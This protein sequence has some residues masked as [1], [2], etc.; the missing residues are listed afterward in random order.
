MVERSRRPLRRAFASVHEASVLHERL[1]RLPD[2]RWKDDPSRVWRSHGAASRHGTLRDRRAAGLHVYRGEALRIGHK[3]RQMRPL[4]RRI[5]R[6][7]TE[8]AFEVLARARA[9]EAQG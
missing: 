7:G 1:D 9:L 4:A 3:M 2:A 6:L 5:G 8:T